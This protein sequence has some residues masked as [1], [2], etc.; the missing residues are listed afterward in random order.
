QLGTVASPVDA[1]RG[2]GSTPRVATAVGSGRDA[3]GGGSS[4]TGIPVGAFGCELDINDYPKKA[5]WRAT[6]RET[7]SQVIEQSGAAIT[8]RGIFVPPGKPVPEGERKL[9]L[10]IEADTER[11]VEQAK[12][13]LKRILTEATLQVMEHEA[14]AGGTGRYSVV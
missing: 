12:G 8:M 9:H 10:S 13:E 3:E 1:A 2:P 7:L 4:S 5:R 6:N 14:R 11:A